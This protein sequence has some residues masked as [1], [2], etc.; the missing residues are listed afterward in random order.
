MPQIVPEKL[1]F[2]L[3][4]FCELRLII[5]RYKRSLIGLRHYDSVAFS[6]SAVRWV[7]GERGVVPYDASTTHARLHSTF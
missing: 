1:N 7:S 4:I 5:G 6:L 3:C 2:D